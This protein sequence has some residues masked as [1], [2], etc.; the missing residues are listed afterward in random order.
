LYHN[1][2]L[3]KVNKEDLSAFI[4]EYSWEETTKKIIKFINFKLKREQKL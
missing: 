1:K 2:N 4:K 3:L